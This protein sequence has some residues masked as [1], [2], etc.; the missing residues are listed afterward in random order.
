MNTTFGNMHPGAKFFTNSM[1]AHLLQKL[2]EKSAS[3]YSTGKH[4]D[5]PNPD[6]KVECITP[7]LVKSI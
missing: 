2:D 4:I 7:L 3:A 1:G 5:V 6:L